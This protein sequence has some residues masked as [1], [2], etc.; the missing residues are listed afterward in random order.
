MILGGDGS[1]STGRGHLEVAADP[2]EGHGH[3]QDLAAYV[4]L[5]G[6]GELTMGL[7]VLSLGL[8]L[9]L[10]DLLL[11]SWRKVTL[12]IE[13]RSAGATEPSG[14]AK[15]SMNDNALRRRQRCLSR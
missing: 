4:L 6:A 7:V 9:P 3:P 2:T 8:R 1:Q 11:A 10:R 13:S 14:M 5:A 15:R 12:M